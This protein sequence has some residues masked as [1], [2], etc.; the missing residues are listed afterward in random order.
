MSCLP[1]TWG[2]G[3]LL[4]GFPIRPFV[5]FNSTTWWNAYSPLSFED[6][7]FPS[8]TYELTN[9]GWI[10]VTVN[11]LGK[12]TNSSRMLKTRKILNS[13]VT[14]MA[15]STV[16]NSDAKARQSPLLQ[17]SLIQHRI[18]TYL[19]SLDPHQTVLTQK[20][21]PPTYAASQYALKTSHNN[22]ES[23]KKLLRFVPIS[24]S[25]PKISE[26]YSTLKPIP[27]PSFMGIC[28]IVF[29]WSWSQT[30][31]QRAWTET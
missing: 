12:Q 29:V 4:W 1:N 14:I 28:W 21:Q 24:G 19:Y 3:A 17:S 6:H 9:C 22:E 31:N 2:A 16:H 27:H 20:Y 23:R 10:Y 13:N 5:F 11:D 30:N 25:L 7:D 18:N 8:K 15:L 26:V